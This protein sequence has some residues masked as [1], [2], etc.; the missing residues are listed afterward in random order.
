MMRSHAG[1]GVNIFPPIIFSAML[2]IFNSIF[3]LEEKNIFITS[4]QLKNLED[5][6][7]FTYKK[8]RTIVHSFIY[9]INYLSIP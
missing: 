2:L 5:I 3:I 7:Q 9:T 6:F 8:E 4:T 1:I